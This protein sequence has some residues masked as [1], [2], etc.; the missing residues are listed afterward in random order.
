MA[1]LHDHSLSFIALTWVV[2]VGHV[3][4]EVVRDPKASQKQVRVY[5]LVLTHHRLRDVDILLYVNIH[6]LV[7]PARVDILGFGHAVI[8]AGSELTNAGQS[9]GC[10]C[11]I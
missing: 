8:G 1:V 5:K 6:V 11:C 9:T 4:D 3:V 7:H 10:Q 2:E